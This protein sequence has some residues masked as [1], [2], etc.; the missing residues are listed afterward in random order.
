MNEEKNFSHWTIDKDKNNFVWLSLDVQESSA[1]VLSA[2]VLSEFHN[3]IESLHLDHPEGLVIYSGKKNGFIMGAD[4][5]GFIGMTDE[6]KAYEL[7]RQGQQVLESFVSLGCPKIAVINGFALG[8]G[9]ELA[10]ACDYRIGIDNKKPILGLPEVK[11][12]L[13]P[14]FGGTVRTIQI[15]GVRPAMKL[16]LTGKSITLK[17]AFQ[18]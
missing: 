14:G 9:L 4:I 1:N 3:I 16:M 17:K 12:G 11:L 15:C 10:M 2:D 6:N 7:I 8:G 13:H 5:K 18:I